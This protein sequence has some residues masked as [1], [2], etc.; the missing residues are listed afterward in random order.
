MRVYL[1]Y[2]NT[3]V[4]DLF[5][6]DWEFHPFDIVYMAVWFQAN[7]TPILINVPIKVSTF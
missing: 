3:V 6:T 7:D 4:I 1:L 2:K 5:Y